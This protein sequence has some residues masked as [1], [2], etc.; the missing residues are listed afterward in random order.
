MAVI[1][2]VRSQDALDDRKIEKC[3]LIWEIL[4]GD[5]FCPLDFSDAKT[6]SSRTRFNEG[7]NV[8]FV[9]ADVVPGHSSDARSRMSEMACLA[10]ELAHAIR[11]SFGL[12]RPFDLPDKL[13]D[14][15]EAS[16]H[17]SW[18]SVL[19][20]YDRYCLVEDASDQL[21]KWLCYRK[22]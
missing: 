2:G 18:F 1:S 12:E 9:G 5:K 3:K 10:H 4:G 19:G 6:H 22:E 8:V 15:A 17:A 20:P 11:A 7:E 16:L 21:I 13:R 14:E